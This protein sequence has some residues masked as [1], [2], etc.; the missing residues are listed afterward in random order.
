[1]LILGILAVPHFEPDRA[2]DASQTHPSL[3]PMLRL[4]FAQGEKTRLGG[5]LPP[6][7]FAPAVGASIHGLLPKP[8]TRS[9]AT[10]PFLYSPNSSF[11]F[12]VIINVI[13]E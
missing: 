2:D 1:M 7:V 9:R 3:S 6:E 12:A 13:F 10:S 4:S 8:P 5:W 11:V